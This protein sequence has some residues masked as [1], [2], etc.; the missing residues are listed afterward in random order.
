MYGS[1]DFTLNQ[2]FENETA[3]EKEDSS[4]DLCFFDKIYDVKI[5]Q[6][7][8]KPGLLT[9]SNHLTSNVNHWIIMP[10]LFSSGTELNDF[11]GNIRI[12]IDLEKK[13]TKKINISAE[14]E[15][16]KYNFTLY[17]NSN[18]ISKILFYVDE[19][20]FL[21]NKEKMCSV[22]KKMFPDIVIE[23]DENYYEN[24]IFCD[25]SWNM[26]AVSVEV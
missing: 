15:Q 16:N 20:N 11:R 10:F 6:I 18:S 12:L 17:Y 13:I 2:E 14:S 24:G 8:N 9:F 7:F 26:K 23:Y 22:L 4:K 21:G 5:S 3:G 19:P 1:N 25:N